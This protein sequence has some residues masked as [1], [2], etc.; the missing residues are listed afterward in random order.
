MRKT[1]QIQRLRVRA[2]LEQTLNSSHSRGAEYFNRVRLTL[3]SRQRIYS[4]D[5]Q[6]ASLQILKKISS[7]LT[8]TLKILKQLSL[9]PI[10][11]NLRFTQ[12]EICL[13]KVVSFLIKVNNPIMIKINNKTQRVINVQAYLIRVF[14]K[15]Q[16]S[17]QAVTYSEVLL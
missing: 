7:H 1:K 8:G 13:G 14:R 12:L 11:K 2:Y 4:E 5:Q 3:N 6:K 9:D 16:T 15:N 10:Q 17:T